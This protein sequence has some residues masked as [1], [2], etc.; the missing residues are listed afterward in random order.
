MKEIPLAAWVHSAENMN[1]PELQDL[2]SWYANLTTWLKADKVYCGSRYAV[3]CVQREFSKLNADLRAE[4]NSKIEVLEMGND[5]RKLD[6][7]VRRGIRCR[8]RPKLTWIG[9]LD[10]DRNPAEFARIVISLLDKGEDFEVVLACKPLQKRLPIWKQM[11]E[12]LQGEGRLFCY[13][14]LTGVDY[15]VALNDTDIVLSTCRQES[16]GFGVAEAV[17]TGAF[18]MVPRAGAYPELYPERF[19]YLNEEDAVC[20]IRELFRKV[21]AQDES[22]E[23]S[24]KSL[25]PVRMRLRSEF[26]WLE[27]REKYLTSFKNMWTQRMRKAPFKLAP[28]SQKAADALD[29]EGEITKRDLVNR[30]I[31]W[32]NTDW[33]YG[34]RY[35]LLMNGYRTKIVDD[36]VVWFKGSI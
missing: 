14:Y 8:K 18:P 32:G 5:Y 22:L 28:S 23:N 15:G 4:I 34:V 1:A 6:D 16:F 17:Y 10:F 29:R 7:Y 3:D 20:R 11:V 33:Y 9:R 13:G 35:R 30:V 27:L 19:L 25:L 21:R 26:D 36:E 2:A 24:Y 12:R 31:G